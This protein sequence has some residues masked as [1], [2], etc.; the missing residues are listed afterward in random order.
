M[1]LTQPNIKIIIIA[2]IF[3]ILYSL[4]IKKTNLWLFNINLHN[5]EQIIK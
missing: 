2:Y 5:F 4:Q 3:F 1:G